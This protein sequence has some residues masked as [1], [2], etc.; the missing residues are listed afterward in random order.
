[1]KKRILSILTAALLL[2]ALLPLSAAGAD[3]GTYWDDAT[4]AY[5]YSEWHYGIV[6][7]RQ[8][9]V[10][11]RASTNGSS[12]GQIKNGQT[13][14]VL[15]I[16]QDNNFYVLDLDSCGFTGTAPGA[17]GYAKSSL[18]KIDPEFIATTRTTNLYA[19]PWTT[20]LKNGEWNN[21]FFLVLA[22]HNDWYAV[23]L[24]ET[25]PGTGFIRARE[26]GDYSSSTGYNFIVSWDTN[27]Y[28][29]GD[30][31]D[32]GTVKRFTPCRLLSSYSGADSISSEYSLV[33]FNAGEK[34]EYSAWI[35]N[36]NIAPILN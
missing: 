1:M 31:K 6:T 7:C 23:Q 21:R 16:T 26:M 28:A 15:G 35:L 17:Y 36:Q 18:I 9:H 13:V 3:G 12:Y 19:T 14:K 29:E 20:E 5:L 22:E 27:V 10:R 8:M 2:L 25:A 11:D 33:L 4:N 24:M 30:W 32:L 34:K